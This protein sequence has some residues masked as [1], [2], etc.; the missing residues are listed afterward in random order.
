MLFR[1]LTHV[2]RRNHVLNGI[3]IGRIHSP[4]R[5]VASRRCGLLLNYSGQLLLFG[6]F[7]KRLPLLDCCLYV[8]FIQ[9]FSCQISSNKLLFDMTRRLAWA[10]S[11]YANAR[12]T[13]MP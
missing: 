5:G 2:G 9:Y 3:K 1:G 13:T 6:E 12:F 7:R 8:A 10:L 11:C 4:W